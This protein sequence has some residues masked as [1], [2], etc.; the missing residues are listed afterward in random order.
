MIYLLIGY[1]Y[2][3]IHRPFEI[4]PALG[5]LRIELVY[6]TILTLAWCVVGKQFRGWS[7]LAG[8]AAMAVAFYFSWLCSPWADKAEDVV[9]NYTFVV[10]FGLIIATC[11]RDERSLYML[12]TA[13]LVVL[14]FYMLHS[15]L[16]Y[17]NGR[18]TFRMGI[19]R[20]VGVDKSLGD[21]NSFGASIVYSLPFLPFLLALLAKQMASPGD[22]VLSAHVGRLHSAHGIAIV[23]PRRR[24]LGTV[25][26]D[27]IAAQDRDLGGI[28]R[29]GRRQLVCP[30]PR[31]CRIDSRRSSIRRSVRPMRKSPAKAVSMGF[32]WA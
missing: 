19:A 29:A 11:V 14:A 32:S 16:E 31:V 4:W 12:V 2:L 9:K 27:A 7:L 10:L 23:A 17:K 18:H 8:I 25:V 13:F 30:C 22:R 15:I 28:V 24:R 1:V 3:C 26:A 21:P 6:F 20:M 5:D